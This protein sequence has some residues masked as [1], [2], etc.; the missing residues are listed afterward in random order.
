M[1]TVCGVVGSSTKL[2]VTDTSVILNN[3]SDSTP[4]ISNNTTAVA[5][6]AVNVPFIVFSPALKA[7]AN[8][9]ELEMFSFEYK[10][11]SLLAV[12]FIVYWYLVPAVR[13]VI[14]GEITWIPQS[15]PDVFSTYKSSGS[16][17]DVP[18]LNAPVPAV[19][20]APPK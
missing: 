15:F 2:S 4:F 12:N 7:W 6:P 20:L 3:V 16:V 11:P 1:S 13:P 5:P 14:S 19:P 8:L 18:P 9:S 10:V 17:N